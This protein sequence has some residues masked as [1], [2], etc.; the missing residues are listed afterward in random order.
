MRSTPVNAERIL[1]I[2][3]KIA[4][5]ALRGCPGQGGNLPAD[6]GKP[7]QNR[8]KKMELTKEQREIIASKRVFQH[9]DELAA[10]VIM[11][12]EFID[13]GCRVET[14]TLRVN[15]E[16][17]NAWYTSIYGEDLA[18]KRNITGKALREQFDELEEEARML[19]KEYHEEVKAIIAEKIGICYKEDGVTVTVK[20]LIS[21]IFAIVKITPIEDK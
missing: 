8:R 21:E 2:K 6:D 5:T 12:G 3:D 13:Q 17:N 7:Q 20:H 11:R 1:Q 16:L 18:E 10:D 4:E 19:S 9:L 14:I 15:G